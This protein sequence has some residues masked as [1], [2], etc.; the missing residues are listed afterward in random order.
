MNTEA[1][2]FLNNTSE[3][4][5]NLLISLNNNSQ[6]QATH[7][8]DVDHTNPISQLTLSSISVNARNNRG[9]SRG[10]GNILPS[11]VNQESRISLLKRPRRPKPVSLTRPSKMRTANSIG[12]GIRRRKQL[13]SNRRLNNSSNILEHISLSEDVSTRTDLKR[14]SNVLVPVVVNLYVLVCSY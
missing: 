13:S 9:I 11:K 8:P 4:N 12:I 5:K 7:I 3:S 6:L 10:G 1:H 2:D 14:M